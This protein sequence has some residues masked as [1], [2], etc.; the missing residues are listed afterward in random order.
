MPRGGEGDTMGS[1]QRVLIIGGTRGTGYQIAG[2]LLREGHPLRVLGRDAAAARRRFSTGVEIM[3]GDITKPATLTAALEGVEHLIFTAGVTGRFVGEREV[4]ATTRDGLT[5]TLAAAREAELPGRFLYMSTVGVTQP[6]AAGAFLDFT[7]RNTLKWR[8]LA[9]EEIRQSGRD[10][11]IIRAGILTND[12]AGRRGIEIGQTPSPLSWER[13]IS[14]DDVAEIF[15]Q[16]L[17]CPRT[18]RTSFNVVGAG[19]PGPM[20]WEAVFGSLHPDISGSA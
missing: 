13:R 5:N 8:R 4:I 9:E 12:P 10:Y 18:S 20:A 17:Q 1:K 19:R 16:A 11:T 3:Q 14:R 2:L 6:S 15:V 7:K